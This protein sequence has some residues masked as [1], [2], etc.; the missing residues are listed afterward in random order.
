[1]ESPKALGIAPGLAQQAAAVVLWHLG[2]LILHSLHMAKARHG[3]TPSLVEGDSQ[4]KQ[5]H[6]WKWER[7]NNLFPETWTTVPIPRPLTEGSSILK[8]Q[9]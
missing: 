1:M 6:E 8:H 2:G 5:H 3:G 4:S 9:W 7:I